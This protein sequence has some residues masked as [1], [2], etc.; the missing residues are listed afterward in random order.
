VKLKFKIIEQK[1]KHYIRLPD[2]YSKEIL[3]SGTDELFGKLTASG[4]LEITRPLGD[5]DL[6]QVCH[7]VPHR[8]SKCINC[9]KLTCAGC[10]WELGSLCYDC[11]SDGKDN[12]G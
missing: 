3:A 2:E 7:K 5:T 9:G 8:N 12:T 4:N 1:G 6:C 11:L 10:F